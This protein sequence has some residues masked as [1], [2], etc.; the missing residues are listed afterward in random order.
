VGG[1][2][3]GNLRAPSAGITAKVTSKVIGVRGS[4]AVRRRANLVTLRDGHGIFFLAVSGPVRMTANN[5]VHPD[6][7]VVTA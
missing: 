1:A 5:G 3:M 4:V 6:R 7:S 2:V